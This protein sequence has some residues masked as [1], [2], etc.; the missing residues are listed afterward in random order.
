MTTL[1]V[2][3]LSLLALAI[4]PALFAASAPSRFDRLGPSQADF[5]GVGLMQAPTARMAR[6]GIQRQLYG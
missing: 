1:P 5:G 3:S 4:S 6:E 2:F